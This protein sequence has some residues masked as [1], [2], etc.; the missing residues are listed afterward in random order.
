MIDI[1]SLLEKKE[2]PERWFTFD[3]KEFP[4]F[5]CKLRYMNRSKLS[6]LATKFTRSIWRKQARQ[7]VDELDTQAFKKAWL[8]TILIGWRGLTFEYLDQLIGLDKSEL[9]NQKIDLT[10]EVPFDLKVAE[11]LIEEA[12]NFDEWLVSMTTD[13]GIFSASSNIEPE[14]K[15]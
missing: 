10:Q 3:P 14:I 13:R 2:V 4:G 7:R 1:K 9:K 6:S 5:E 8:P 11:V 12:Y 15:N